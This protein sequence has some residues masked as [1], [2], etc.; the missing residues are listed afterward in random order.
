MIRRAWR[1]RTHEGAWT[2]RWATSGATP[3]VTVAPTAWRSP[4][5]A[6]ETSPVTKIPIEIEV[7]PSAMALQAA[8]TSIWAGSS[9][10]LGT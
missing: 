9:V 5:A 3:A 8:S 1:G 6:T 2:R 4:S 10:A 7:R